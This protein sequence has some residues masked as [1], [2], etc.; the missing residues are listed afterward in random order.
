MTIKDNRIVNLIEGDNT[1]I[2]IG[3]S[4]DPRA[5]G[6]VRKT[7]YTSGTHIAN[8][9]YLPM[10]F[11][12]FIRGLLLYIATLGKLNEF[13]EAPNKKALLNSNTVY[14]ATNRDKR[15]DEENER[16]NYYEYDLDLYCMALSKSTGEL[17]K[18]GPEDHNLLDPQKII[19]H[20]G[21]ENTGQGIYDDETIS[22]DL[23]EA[24]EFYDK[25]I[26]YVT[27]DCSHDFSKYDNNPTLRFVTSKT[28][29]EITKLTIDTE[30]VASKGCYGYIF[31][32]VYKD[33]DIWKAKVIDEFTVDHE[34]LLNIV[35]DKLGG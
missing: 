27:S 29:K 7:I 26:I 18:V 23:I 24:Q 9:I 13:P 19:I 31:A 10:W 2:K 11:I 3:L 1:R 8:I 20:S 21:D 5:A 14:S 25:F 6:V 30:N 33:S 32:M 28:E 12:G 16:E 15:H 22:L 35:K 17:I 4:W 34:S